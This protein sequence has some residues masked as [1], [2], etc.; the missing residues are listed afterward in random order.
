MSE[1]ELLQFGNMLFNPGIYYMTVHSLLYTRTV[2][3]RYLSFMHHHTAIGCATNMPQLLPE[4]IHDIC[5]ELL[6]T[7]QIIGDHLIDDY[8]AQQ[9][10]SFIWIEKTDTPIINRLCQYMV[11]DNAL[12]PHVP[13][14]IL[15]EQVH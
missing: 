12:L 4:V 14:V 15:A 9:E 8:F 2:L 11:T 3:L 13:I 7:D 1:Q 6:M 10:F 5:A